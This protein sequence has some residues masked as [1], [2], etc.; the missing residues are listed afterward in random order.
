[1]SKWIKSAIL[2]ASLLAT[3]L[4]PLSEAAAGQRYRGGS[5]YGG[6]GGYHHGG[7]YRPH[8]PRHDAYRH[9]HKR[10]SSRSDAVAAGIIGLAAGAIIGSALSQP[11]PPPPRSRPQV[12]YQEPQPIYGGLEPWSPGWY[13]HCSRRYR[14]FNPNTGTFRGYDGRDHFCVAD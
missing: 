11:A 3:C 12:I 10:R 2:S 1:M 4:A 7:S 14:S 9:G 8:H 13:N 6:G 5:H